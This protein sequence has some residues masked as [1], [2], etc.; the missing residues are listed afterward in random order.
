M[1]NIY[2][3][4]ESNNKE[5]DKG[6]KFSNYIV[7]GGEANNSIDTTKSG[8]AVDDKKYEDGFA[9]P[10]NIVTGGQVNNSTG[11]TTND[12]SVDDRENEDGFAKQWLT[13]KASKGSNIA[14]NGM[15]DNS[16]K[17]T[18]GLKDKSNQFQILL[19]A[20]MRQMIQLIQVKMI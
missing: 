18:K 5:K 17:T 11:T 12:F 2:N 10:N 9:E 14:G 8:F 4:Q 15:A 19:L 1:K 20:K 3:A 13:E 6:N 16:I 7:A